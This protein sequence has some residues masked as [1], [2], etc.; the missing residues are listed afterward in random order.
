M[1]LVAD[2]GLGL[3]QV[4]ADPQRV[5]LVLSNLL[6]NAIR[7]SP[8]GATVEIAVAPQGGQV[9]FTVTDH[10]EG[11]PAEYQA[12]I[13]DRFFRVPGASSGAAGL[14]LPLAKEVVESHG[15]RIGVES[16]VGRGSKFWFTLPNAP[17]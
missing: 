9:R 12:A 10:G 15:G 7:H 4:M 14:G 5:Q 13:F 2:V 1:K 17:S 11:I 6:G 8:E 16:Q 3:D